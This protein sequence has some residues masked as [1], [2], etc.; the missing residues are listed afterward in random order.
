M[1]FVARAP[2]FDVNN[3]ARVGQLPE[4]RRDWLFRRFSVAYGLS[5]DR[6]NLDD[7]RF[8]Q[9]MPLLL[10]EPDVPPERPQAPTKDEC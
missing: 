1:P 8:P 10:I 5:F 3:P 6:A 9:D 4:A 2:V 7:H